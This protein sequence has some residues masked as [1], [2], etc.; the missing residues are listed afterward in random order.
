MRNL[1][2]GQKKRKD[3]EMMRRDILPQERSAS[4]SLLDLHQFIHSQSQEI[5][6]PSGDRVKEEERWFLWVEDER[7]RCFFCK[8]NQ[9]CVSLASAFSGNNINC[10]SLS[11]TLGF[12]I[13]ASL[14]FGDSDI[15]VVV[16]VRGQTWWD[17]FG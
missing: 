17:S 6:E 9:R 11:G 7:G 15:C 10:V 5:L 2:A 8:G 14:L 4:A 1:N 13:Y 3:T 16:L 12:P